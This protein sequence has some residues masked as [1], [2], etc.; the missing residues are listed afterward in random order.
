MKDSYWLQYIREA[1]KSQKVADHYRELAEQEYERRYGVHP[2]DVD[3]DYWID[4]LSC[5]DNDD[6]MDVNLEMIKEE[7]KKSKKRH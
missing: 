4:T 2:T 5:Y 3:D 1:R 6:P 7:G